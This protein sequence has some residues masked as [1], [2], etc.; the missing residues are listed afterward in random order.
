M[1]LQYESGIK[2]IPYSQQRVFDKLSDFT[3]LKQYEDR[4]SEI[5]SDTVKVEDLHFST[6]SVSCRVSPV[7]SLDLHIVEREAP[8]CIKY[9]ATTSP[10]PITIWAQILPT[11][12]ESCKLKLTLRT[13]LNFLL[14]GMLQKPLQEG[15]EKL[16]D[17]LAIMPY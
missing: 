17:T 4:L 14:K 13:E 1:S 9:E 3:L 15:L 5:P 12:D 11:G 8:K 2:Q 7:G 16:A 6:D 10:I